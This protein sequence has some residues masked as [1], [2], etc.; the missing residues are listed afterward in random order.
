M[1][2]VRSCVEE[3]TGDGSRDGP[4]DVAPANGGFSVVKPEPAAASLTVTPH[5]DTA[6]LVC[7]YRF[8]PT[9]GLPP[10]EDRID[11]AFIDAGTGTLQMKH[12]GTGK[13]FACGDD[14]SEF[15]LVPVL[16]GRP[17]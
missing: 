11:V 5:F 6:T 1:L 2:D 3:L 13:V 9:D 4:I 16:T 12:N 10:R 17:R 7:S 15:L 8:T 14:L